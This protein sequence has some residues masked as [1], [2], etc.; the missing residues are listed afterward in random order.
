LGPPWSF[1]HEARIANSR[2]VFEREIDSTASIDLSIALP[3]DV[4]ERFVVAFHNCSKQSAQI[5]FPEIEQKD[6]KAREQDTCDE[7]QRVLRHR[8]VYQIENAGGHDQYRS[9]H[10]GRRSVTFCKDV[11]HCVVQVA[12]VK[13]PNLPLA[14]LR[15][16][17]AR[18][19]TEL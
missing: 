13:H 10:E 1:F 8:S 18:A 19:I 17:F 2:A 5:L 7:K 11:C 4:L 14:V 16:A 15:S 12:E 6:P 9:H 3:A